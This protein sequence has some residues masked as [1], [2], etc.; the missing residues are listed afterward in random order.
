VFHTIVGLT[1]NGLLTASFLTLGAIGLTLTFGVFRFANLAHADFVTLGAY[2]VLVFT[3]AGIPFI[4]AAILGAVAATLVGGVLA[5]LVFERLGITGVIPL[6]VVSIGLAILVRYSIQFLFGPD[7][8]QFPLPM[9]RPHNFGLFKLTTVQID[10]M[11][12]AVVVVIALRLL[13]AYTKLGRILRAL[14]DNPMLCEVSGINTAMTRAIAW[15]LI[16]ALAAIAGVLLGMNFVVQPSMGWDFFIP[17]FSA[18][19]LG[20][21]GNPRGALVG[22]IIIGLAQEYSTLILP[23]EYKEIV[24]FVVLTLCLFVRPSGIWSVRR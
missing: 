16:V 21:V 14:A 17:I 9:E 20:G 3:A 11:A 2:G 18:A 10:T 1:V 12:V 13:L 19:I 6:L 7:Y 22:A 4:P 24:S 23:P 15:G 8:Q 5:W